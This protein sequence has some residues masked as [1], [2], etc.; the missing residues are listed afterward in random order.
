MEKLQTDMVSFGAAMKKQGEDTA[1]ALKAVNASLASFAVNQTTMCENLKSFSSW[2]PTV[3]GSLHALQ[4]SLADVGERVAVLE[5]A[6]SSDDDETP[7]PDG[8]REDHHPQ[9]IVTRASKAMAPAL[10]KGLRKDIQRA[11]RLHHPRT[12][13]AALSLAETQEELSEESRPLSPPSRYKSNYQ[14]A[15]ARTGFPGKGILNHKHED[16]DKGDNKPQ[17]QNKFQLLKAQRRE[18][19]ECFKCGDKFHP[20]HKCSKSV[21]INLVEEL[22]E[23][24]QMSVGDSEG[25]ESEGNSSSEE[26]FMHMSLGAIGG[27]VKKKSLRLQGTIRDK[28]VLILVDSGSFGNF[29]SST[30]V[31]Q[32]G[33]PTVDIDPVTV[34]VANGAREQVRTAVVDVPWECQGATFT[35]SFRVFDLPSYDIIVGM[36]WLDTL[37]PMWMDWKKK[38]FRIKQN[39]KR[40]T[41]KGVQDKTSSCAFISPEELQQLEKDMAILHIVQLSSATIDSSKQD[42]PKEIAQVL[43]EHESCFGTPKGL[44]PHRPY[45]HK[46]N[47]MQ[48]VQ[49]V[50]VRPYRYSPQ[51]KDE[52]EKQIKEMLVQGIIKESKSPFA[53]PVLLVKKKDGTWRFCIDYR[54]LNAVTVKDRYPMPVVEEL[55]DELAGAKFFTKLDL[56]SGFHQIRMVPH[57][58]SKTA[59]RTHNGHYEF[60]V[61][62]FGLSCAPATFQAAMNTV[63][64]HIIRKYVLVFVDDILV[65]SST[66]QDHKKHLDTVLQLLEQNKLY[67]KRSKCSFAQQSLEYLGHIISADGVSTDPT[68]IE[69]VQHWPQPTNPTQLRGFLGLAGYYRKFIRHF[70]IISRPLTDLLKKNKAFVWSPVVHDAF[71][72]LKTALVQ[73][74]VLALPD[75]T[76]DFVLEA[77]ACATGVVCQQAKSEHVRYPGKLQ[78]LPIP[79]EAWHTVGMDFIEGLPVSNKFD[80]ILVVVDKLTKFGHFIPLKHPF[81]ATTVAQAFFDTVYRLHGLPKA[82][83][84]LT[85]PP[86]PSAGDPRPP[87]KRRRKAPPQPSIDST[88]RAPRAAAAAAARRT[89][90][91]G[92]F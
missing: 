28:Q 25:E 3:E 89:D 34:T 83:A 53:S 14:P 87:E 86:M 47:L 54:Q 30:A 52:I 66:I 2:M 92:W 9:G 67:V 27:T 62:P 84:D 79:K 90:C 21:P 51:Q 1:A 65:Y 38:V 44:P 4:L 36:D 16:K 60:L 50:N 69:A 32:L 58:E 19:G 15:Y 74:P 40:I 71:L 18:R 78:P 33:L 10:G 23:I 29:I 82:T 43:R 46:I 88:G 91:G 64:A 26:T 48:G 45:D 20:G 81:T 37:G 24:L 73:A 39:G 8:H 6:L 35:T 12:V 5:S 55:L 17:W 85:A 68:K 57:D 75:F 42:L 7:R 63:F 76:K 77:D 22:V 49:P 13:D 61:M 72:S 59:F 41:I 31:E 11:I 80:T 70:G 56:R